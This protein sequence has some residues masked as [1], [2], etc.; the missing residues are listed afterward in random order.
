MI[1][2]EKIFRE[3]EKKAPLSLAVEG[4]RNGFLGNADPADIDVERVAVMMDYLGDNR[5]IDY[6]LLFLHHPPLTIPEVPSYVAHSN[7]DIAPGGACDALAECLGVEAGGPLDRITGNGRIGGFIG[8]PVVLGD[9]CISVAERLGT[10]EL[11]LVNYEEE[12][13]I[14]NCAVVS[15]FGLNPDYIR[16][17]A[18]AGADLIVSGDLTHKGAIIAKNTGISIIDA[19]HHTT[20]LPGLYRL[21]GLIEG[22]GVETDTI[23]TGTPWTSVS[24]N[25]GGEEFEP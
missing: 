15:G 4:D 10:D 2:A 21:G 24:M 13:V 1:K 3:I 23:D 6:D 11:R 16:M 25:G 7:W 17:A 14:E 19:S 9:F 22:L 18:D 20:E 5:Y 8:G 12:R